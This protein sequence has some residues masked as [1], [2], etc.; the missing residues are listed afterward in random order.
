MTESIRTMLRPYAESEAGPRFFDVYRTPILDYFFKYFPFLGNEIQYVL[1]LPF[2]AW[3]LDPSNLQ[4]LTLRICTR[5]FL[6]VLAANTLKDILCLERCGPVSKRLTHDVDDQF[7]F[8]STH[9]SARLAYV[10]F[11]G[12][13]ALSLAELNGKVV[14]E[15][16]VHKACGNTI[17]GVEKLCEYFALVAADR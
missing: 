14:D 9:L 2:A 4:R 3:I 15:D 12:D 17:E 10:D 6:S 7:G 11:D 5:W 8:P 16:L 13:A 1:L